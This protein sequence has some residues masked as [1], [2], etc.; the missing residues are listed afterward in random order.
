VK[1][2][3]Q[4]P[5]ISRRVPVCRGAVG[6][7]GPQFQKRSV[8]PGRLPE[9]PAAHLNANDPTSP[10]ETHALTTAVEGGALQLAIALQ[11]LERAQHRWPEGAAVGS[12]A[13]MQSMVD[14]LCGLSSRDPLTGLANRRQFELTLDREIDRVARSGEPALVLLA[15]IDHFKRVNDSFGHSAGDRVI[16]AVGRVLQDTVRPMDTVARIGGE[17][18]AIVLP[19]CAPAFGQAVA[20]RIRQRVE[21]EAVDISTIGSGSAH[22]IKA[23]ISLGG[24]FAPQWVRSSARLWLERADQQLYLA[25]SSGRNCAC[26]EMPPVLVVSSEEKGL[27]FTLPVLTDAAGEPLTNP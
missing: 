17:E 14:G 1:D 11:L 24:A 27:L 20:E 7:I 2:A 22:L 15:D 6:Y 19:N 8:L 10:P 3:A 5:A 12:P 16:Q 9:G 23:T 13:W 25:K 26:L 21:R 4:K 18:F